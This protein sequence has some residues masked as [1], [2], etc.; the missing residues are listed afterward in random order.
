MFTNPGY[1]SHT[2]KE[3]SA[4]D[5]CCTA[6]LLHN[7]DI[8]SLPVKDLCDFISRELQ[9]PLLSIQDLSM[10]MQLH[11]LYCTLAIISP[12][13]AEKFHQ[14]IANTLQSWVSPHSSLVAP[15]SGY[16]THVL[17]IFGATLSAAT[18]RHYSLM[19][20]EA[21]RSYL[22]SCF[23]KTLGCFCSDDQSQEND[24]RVAYTCVSVGYC[25]NLLEDKALFGEPLI[26]YFLQAQAYDGGSCSNN[27]G[28]ESHGAYT[29]CSLAGLYI[30]L[31]CSSAALRDRLGERRV[32]DLLLYIHAKQ[33]NQGGFAGRNNKLVD[34]CYTYWMMGSLYLLVG[35]GEFEDFMVI[36]A[37]ALYKYVLR[38][39]YDRGAPDGKR[40]MRDKPGVP[41]DAYHNMYTTA[42]YLILLR[43]VSLDKDKTRYSPELLAEV[44]A[45]KELF[46]RHDPLFNIPAGSANAMR[47]FFSLH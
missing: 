27:F 33:T 37:D 9:K 3:E 38:C 23:N 44:E 39:S 28:G 5:A 45:Q 22:I 12:Q 36:D 41:S 20:R 29:F 11:W 32:L 4:I 16:Q 8:T 7:E 42:G 43:L 15:H 34:G 13:T 17:I 1:S 30:L 21:V 46:M 2:V 10:S 31:G 19:S 26:S 40:G 6:E 24:M 25:Y 35:D 47:N 18:A 14:S